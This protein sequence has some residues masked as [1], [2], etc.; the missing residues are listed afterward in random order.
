MKLLHTMQHRHIDT[1]EFTLEAIDDII[2]R[3]QNK[4]WVELRDAIHLSEQVARDVK[5][6]CD[7]YAHEEGELRYHFWPVY[8]KHTGYSYL[9]GEK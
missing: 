6:V 9:Y 5:K 2:S 8:L 3:G 1:Q 4:D 7:H